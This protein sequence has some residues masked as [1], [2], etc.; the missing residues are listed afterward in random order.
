MLKMKKENQE[1]IKNL[2]DVDTTLDELMEKQKL[3]DALVH[4]I[5]KRLGIVVLK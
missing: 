4:Q 3:F 2:N 1:Q 5:T